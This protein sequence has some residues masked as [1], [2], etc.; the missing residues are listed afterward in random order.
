[1][2]KIPF[3]TWQYLPLISCLKQFVANQ[4][5]AIKLSYCHNHQHEHGL[6]EVCDV[7]DSW[8]YQNLCNRH[9]VIRGDTPDK[10]RTLNHKYFHQPHDLALG[11]STDG[12]GIFKKRKEYSGWPLVVFNYNLPPDLCMKRKYLLCLGCVPGKAW[13][14]DS[15]LHPL[16][17]EA[18]LLA[19]GVPATDGLNNNEGFMLFAYFFLAICRHTWH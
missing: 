17:E 14:F 1:V 4:D 15:F 5:M 11:F 7:F 19:Q 2:K 9:V 16:Q 13:D 18:E 12:V 3:K 10:D 8:L 6:D